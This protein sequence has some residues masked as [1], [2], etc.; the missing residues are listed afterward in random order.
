MFVIFVSQAAFQH[1]GT[2]RAPRCAISR[3]W[4]RWGREKVTHPNP[5]P[6]VEQN[7]ALCWS[8][9]SKRLPISHTR[10]MCTRVQR[11]N[12]IASL[13]RPSSLIREK[14]GWDQILEKNFGDFEMFFK[15]YRGRRQIVKYL[16]DLEGNQLSKKYNFLT[17][18]FV[19]FFCVKED[20]FM[21]LKF[22]FLLCPGHTRLS[23][24]TCLISSLQRYISRCVHSA[25][26]QEFINL[27]KLNCCPGTSPSSSKPLKL[28]KQSKIADFCLSKSVSVSVT[29]GTLE[30][31]EPDH[32]RG[33]FLRCCLVTGLQWL[34]MDWVDWEDDSVLYSSD[35]RDRPNVYWDGEWSLE[36]NAKFLDRW[37]YASLLILN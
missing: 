6:R 26:L 30:S 9:N 3:W 36:S 33:P 23:C 20:G 17:N 1:F 15:I 34:L 24:T 16:S 12:N 2:I 13:V 10:M 4:V 27:S 8:H 5:K 14:T 21:T 37:L 28:D 18:K 35:G 11:L 32:H 7:T 22:L 29:Q 25:H 19:K 31:R